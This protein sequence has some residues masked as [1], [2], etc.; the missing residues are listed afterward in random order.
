M[1]YY[2]PLLKFSSWSEVWANIRAAIQREYDRLLTNSM[3]SN[4]D[5]S[6]VA[7]ISRVK[8]GTLEESLW[9]GTLG[10]LTQL[11]DE[12]YGVAPMIMIDEYD[13]PIQQGNF[14]GFCD[15]TAGEQR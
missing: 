7:Y 12:V 11:L 14:N 2:F 15:K 8:D 9:P 5:D 6:D 4:M 3:I 1:L 10:R 13:T